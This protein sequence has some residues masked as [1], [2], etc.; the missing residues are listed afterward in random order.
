MLIYGSK[1]YFKSNVV[2][3]YGECQHCGTYGKQLSYRA[4]KFGHLYFIPLLPMG[5]KSQV[6][7]ECKS[8]N[9]GMHIAVN[10]LEPR[11]ESLREQFKSWIGEIQDGNTEITPEGAEEPINVGLLVSGILDDMYCL[12]EIESVES[13]SMI[14]ADMPYENHLVV[15]RWNEIHG[16]L[17]TASQ[18][19]QAAHQLKPDDD[20]A[21]IQWARTDVKLGNVAGAEQA[22][23]AYLAKNPEDLGALVELAG[24]FENSKDFGKLV[25]AYDRIYDIHPE[26]VTD[27]GMKKVY[28]K[29]CKKSGNPGKYLSQM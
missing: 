16:D 3:S 24:V 1:M 18:E 25:A 26:F 20:V 10:E 4:S 17:Q 19:Y 27:K 12:N 2:K 5:G 9:R 7:N 8:C 21:L 15:A 14:L 28:K 6:L 29:A 23:E 22:F 13:I 11:L